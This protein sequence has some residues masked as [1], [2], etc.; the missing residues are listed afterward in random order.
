MTQQKFSIIALASIAVIA[1]VAFGTL[2]STGQIDNSVSTSEKQFIMIQN[3]YTTVDVNQM[4]EIS[5]DIVQGEIVNKYQITQYRDKDGNYVKANSKEIA[6]SEPYIVYELLTTEVIKNTKT[7]TTVY[8]FKI[9]GGDLNDIQIFTD[10]P[11]L[12][13]GDNVIVLL[14]PSLDGLYQEITSGEFGVYKI[15]NGQATNTN[16]V[17][18]VEQ[19]K[20]S[21]R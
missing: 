13:I 10:M 1:V 17:I 8:K 11:E 6:Q 19:L 18:S 16:S 3:S 20:E 14:E 4:I 9:F 2:A 5:S 7:D 15:S 12:K 21:L